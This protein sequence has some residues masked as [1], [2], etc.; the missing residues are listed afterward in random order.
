[1]LYLALW[2]FRTLVKTATGFTPSQLVY[3]LESILHVECEI[4]SLKLAI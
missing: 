3:K 4:P 2:A 1:M